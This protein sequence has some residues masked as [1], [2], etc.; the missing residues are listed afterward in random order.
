MATKGGQKG[1]RNAA[2]GRE[3]HEALRYALANYEDDDIKRGQALKRIGKKLIEQALAGDMQAIKE[4]GDRIDGKAVQV[5]DATIEEVT[6]ADQ[7]TDAQL[8]DIASRSSARATQ[9]KG[10]KKV[11]H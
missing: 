10:G 5:I 4:I 6:S 3:W 9:S 1:N 7:L 11:T 8:L 2:K